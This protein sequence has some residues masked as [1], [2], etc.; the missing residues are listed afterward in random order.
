MSSGVPPG[1]YKK[2]ELFGEPFR[3]RAGLLRFS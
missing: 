3:E 1:G 2:E